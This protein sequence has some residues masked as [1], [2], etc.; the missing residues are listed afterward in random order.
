MSQ[1]K[2]ELVL[3]SI[4]M[5]WGLSWL[6][7]KMGIEGLSPLDIVFLRFSVAFIA[8][9]VVFRRRLRGI[10]RSTALCA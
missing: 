2:S 10:S 6:F 3:I 7:M 9:A 8:V 4:A 5:A 1:R